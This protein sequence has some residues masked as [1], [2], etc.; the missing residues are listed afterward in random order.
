MQKGFFQSRRKLLAVPLLHPPFTPRH[1]LPE[2]ETGEVG[3]WQDR[4]AFARDDRFCDKSCEGGALPGG[5]GGAVYNV[6]PQQ[7]LQSWP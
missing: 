4:A 5:G 7:L 6:I 1:P 3:L 2:G